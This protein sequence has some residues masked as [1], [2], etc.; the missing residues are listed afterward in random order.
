M[1]HGLG[2]QRY[3]Q[4]T[5]AGLDTISVDQGLEIL[6]SLIPTQAAQVGVLSLHW[7]AFLKGLSRPAARA[8]FPSPE[9]DPEPEAEKPSPNG[10]QHWTQA[11]Q[12]ALPGEKRK[13]LIDGISQEV[14]K[15]LMHE[16]GTLIDPAQPLLDLGVDSLVAV[17]LTQ[18]LASATAQ[19]LPATLVFDYPTVGD[20][21]DFLEG[22]LGQE[23]RI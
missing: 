21:A 19:D 2:P 22:S 15:V 1:A 5:A 9:I 7:P 10:D 12:E 6:G 18:S 17:E 13:L 3:Q 20:L 23:E 16:P 11:F 14:A 4:W 8:F